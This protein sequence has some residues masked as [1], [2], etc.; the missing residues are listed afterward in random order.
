MNFS[1][2]VLCPALLWAAFSVYLTAQDQQDPSSE[3][4]FQAT[5]SLVVLDVTVLDKR[6]RPVVNGLT[7]DDFTITE[8]K[9][10]Q[11]IFSFEAPEVHVVDANAGDENPEGKAPVT[12]FVLDLLNSSF[13]DFAFIR[14]SMQ[15]YLEAQP[16]QLNSPAELM[17]IGNDSLEMLRGYT[18]NRD[19]LLNALN[20]FPPVLPYTLIMGEDIHRYMQR[21][22][23]SFDALQQIALQNQAM[24]GRKNIVW[25]GYGVGIPGLYLQ[26]SQLRISGAHKLEQYLH[27]TI[28][29]LLAARMS[30]FV[31]YP[32][33]DSGDLTASAKDSYADFGDHDPFEGGINFGVFVNETGG[34]L[35]YNRNDVDQ[36]IE[37]S[38]QLGS[39]Y[40]TLSY[41]PQDVKADDTFRRIR[42]TLRDRNLHAL[43]KAGYFALGRVRVTLGQ[44][45]MIAVAQAA[46]STHPS[47]ALD[48][49]VS[50]VVRHPDTNTAG[51]TVQLKSK[52]L[53]WRVA[54]NG[55][56][57]ADLIVEAVSLTARGDILASKVDRV[58]VWSEAQVASLPLT[59]QVPRSTQRVRVVVEIGRRIG[60]VDLD[61]KTIDASP[62]AP[63]PAI[64]R[65][66]NGPSLVVSSPG[67]RITV[68]ELE[69]LLSAVHGKPDAEIARQLSGI[70]LTERLSSA[71]LA[72]GEAGL[73]GSESR[74]ALL[75]LADVSQFLDLPASEVPATRAPDRDAQRRV[76]VLALHYVANTIQ[77]LPNFLAT[78]VT[79]SFQDVP[80]TAINP[81]YLPLHS[82][83]R[84]SVTVLYRDRREVVDPGARK[85]KKSQP[86][87]PLA[88]WG[89]F[90]PI[91]GRVLVD[92]A[93]GT[94]A[95]SHWEQGAAGPEAVF[96]YKVPKEKSHYEVGY[97]CAPGK[98][99]NRVLEQMPGYHG[100]IAINPADGT[101]FRVTL[102]ADLEPPGPVVQA[103]VMVEY[104][105]REIGGKT[106]ICPV[107]SVSLQVDSVPTASADDDDQ[108]TQDDLLERLLN[109]P[110]TV[111]T[112]LN[113]VVFEQY[114]LFRSQARMVLN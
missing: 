46:L 106:Y 39:E 100:E 86:A 56:N 24:P 28:N 97:C 57:T 61:R 113:D 63:T 92:A 111:Q 2:L 40:Y 23:Q 82:V 72:H 22:A 7:K 102:Q 114:H 99:K 25:V 9:K 88:T 34:K 103:D 90:G 79:T 81:V 44:P 78:R 58:T 71:R 36:E 107:R 89:V 10:A 94:L 18:R 62:V 110:E 49:T 74:Q 31:I 32:G 104:G 41:Q 16:A 112:L 5:S 17:V 37:R 42:V 109:S 13:E 91:L 51:F 3:S 33:L 87:A 1:R 66:P 19:D 54:G 76:I 95:W 68:Q 93:Q 73:P 108:N 14:Y 20:H 60:T 101:I 35:F 43:T 64:R 75:T 55:Q 38:Q 77:Q 53:G 30:L 70:E 12:I 52:G 59:V 8:D 11:T 26:R 15:K 80:Q 4:T 67:E 45:G 47:Q 48:L 98:K 85:D 105:P 83:D 21:V 27:S 69:Q 96:R 6:G 65:S 29:M 50:G 84:S